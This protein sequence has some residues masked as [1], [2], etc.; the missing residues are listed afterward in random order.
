LYEDI[1][2][3]PGFGGGPHVKV[4]RLLDAVE[5]SPGVPNWSYFQAGEVFA[6]APTFVGGTRVGV[7]RTG[8]FDN[9]LT[10]AGTNGG[11]HQKTFDQ[12]SINDLETYNPLQINQSFPFSATFLGGIYVG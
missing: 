4:F 3:G 9:I 2:T 1:I 8:S 11:P 6:Y 12:T 7:V 10:G 5:S